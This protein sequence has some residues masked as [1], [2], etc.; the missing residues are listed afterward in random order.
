MIQFN[1]IPA[2][3]AQT[4]PEIIANLPGWRNRWRAPDRR[5]I[6]EWAEDFLTLP[7]TY[8]VPGPFRASPWMRP[9]FDWIQSSTVREVWVMAA[10]QSGKTL[11][12]DVSIPWALVNQPGPTMLTMQAESDSKEHMK[13]RLWPVFRSCAPLMALMPDDR[14]D[15]NTLEIYFGSHFFIANGA[16]LNALQSKSIQWKFNDELWLP[17]WEKLYIH[18]KGRVSAFENVGASKIINVSQAG[19]VGDVMETGYKSGT[20]RVWTVDGHPLEFFGKRDDGSRWGIVWNDDAKR[21]DGSWNKARVIETCRSWIT[22]DGANRLM[23]RRA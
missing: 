11:I 12:S 1:E 8:A 4:S 9:I 17:Q 21:T 14:H 22:D 3:A 6:Y 15:R 23:V 19:D 18:A 13:T 7:Q 10:I 20:C 2:A 5:P 16:N